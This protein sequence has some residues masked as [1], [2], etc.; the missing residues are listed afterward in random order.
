MVLSNFLLHHYAQYSIKNMAISRKKK[1]N[2]IFGAI[3]P[4]HPQV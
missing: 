3:H 2:P 4:I 1:G